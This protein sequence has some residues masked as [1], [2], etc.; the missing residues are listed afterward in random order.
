MGAYVPAHIIIISDI[1][2]GIVIGVSA[3]ATLVSEVT[4]LPVSLLH[5]IFIAHVIAGL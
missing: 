4:C 5:D 1:G 2:Q 3:I